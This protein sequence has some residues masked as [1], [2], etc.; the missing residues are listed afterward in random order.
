MSRV[1]RYLL[2][3]QVF[4]AFFFIGRTQELDSLP[5]IISQDAPNQNTVSSNENYQFKE[6]SEV[7]K[8]DTRNVSKAD[9]NK[10]KSD[11]DY[12]YINQVPPKER[13]RSTPS[14]NHKGKK[15]DEDQNMTRGLFKNPWLNVLFWIVLI[16]GFIA[17]LVWFLTTS[18]ISLF[19]KKEKIAL[20][21]IQEAPTDNIFEID[22]EKEIDKAVNAENFRM[23]VRLM[24]LRTLKDLSNH[25]L[26]S[27]THEKT[28]SDYLF[29]LAS[30]S[31]YYKNFFRLTRNFEYIWYGQFEL[32]QESFAIIQNDFL[33]FKQKLS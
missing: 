11:Q 2:A 12:W 1:F 9:L 14:E 7:G 27:Y 18:G 22:F 20:E 28:N 16:G 25:N 10:L 21:Q 13:L 17:L 23:A 26:I 29:Q 5:S 8:I 15:E 31:S 6:P 24:Y 30:L 3:T 33:S 19:R 32:S 4:L